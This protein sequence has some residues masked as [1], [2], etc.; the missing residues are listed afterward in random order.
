MENMIVTVASYKGGVCKTTTA[1]HL[2]AYL[3]SLAPTIL[4]DADLTRNALNW[5]TRGAEG[6]A[7]PFPVAPVDHAAKRARDYQHIVIDT[8]QR[9]TGDDLRAAV[10]GCDLLVV[11]AVPAPIDTDGLLQTVMALQDVGAKAYVVLLAKVAPHA[12]KDAADLRRI[13]A[14]M[15]APVLDT[16]IPMLKVFEKAAGIGTTV[17]KVAE[18]RNAQR[19]WEAYA[20]TGKAVTHGR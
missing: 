6:K 3:Q 8:G 2:A 20:A 9:P 12:A 5:S 13:L 15:K 11:P 1:I 17:D 16:E 10:E 14:D 18:D 4:F 7:L 19:A